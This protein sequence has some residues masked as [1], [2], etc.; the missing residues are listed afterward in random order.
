MFH[1]FQALRIFF[2]LVNDLYIGDPLEANKTQEIC[3]LSKTLLMNTLNSGS[4]NPLPSSMYRSY[5]RI[6]QVNA[7]TGFI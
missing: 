6:P 7:H 5:N 1:V 4:V 2:A 3:I